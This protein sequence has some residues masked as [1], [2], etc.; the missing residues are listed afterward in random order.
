[1]RIYPMRLHILTILIIAL[2][3]DAFGFSP[4]KWIP[5]VRASPNGRFCFRLEPPGSDKQ[6]DGTET[7]FP[8]TGIA[9]SVGEKGEWKELW[10][11]RDWYSSNLL[12]ANDGEHLVM[13]DSNEFENADL[14]DKTPESPER[15]DESTDPCLFFFEK[16]TLIRQ[17]SATEL[18]DYSSLFY[19]GGDWIRLWN[20]AA[21]ELTWNGYGLRI[22][23]ADGVKHSFA[24]TSGERLEVEP[25]VK[26]QIVHQSV[27]GRL[28]IQLDHRLRETQSGAVLMGPIQF[29]A[30]RNSTPELV[31]W[32]GLACFT[33]S[34]LRKVGASIAETAPNL[35]VDVRTGNRPLGLEI[36]RMKCLAEYEGVDEYWLADPVTKSVS[37]FVYSRS[38]DLPVA[39]YSGNDRF[40]TKLM[41]GLEIT[42]SDV[43]SPLGQDTEGMSQAS[44]KTDPT[45][46]TH[47]APLLRQAQD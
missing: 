30:T 42:C 25:P 34:R 35:V 44:T 47:V 18:I 32:D 37:V 7:R 2:I 28:F 40:G 14:A 33:A 3:I 11:M 15:R 1:M 45:P 21:P 13:F 22:T 8:A 31:S 38:T 46:A 6:E 16:G 26:D 20:G 19:T 29:R 39:T 5:V 10:R 9:Y 41:P 23:T 24:M 43:F 36:L 4:A 17:Y 27:L 12:L